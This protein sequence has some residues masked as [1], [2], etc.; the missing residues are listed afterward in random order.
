MQRPGTAGSAWSTPG[1]MLREHS[2]NPGIGMVSLSARGGQGDPEA[3]S[4]HSGSTAR[5]RSGDRIG[6]PN[7]VKSRVRRQRT[8]NAKYQRERRCSESQE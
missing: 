7:S 1:G 4:N 3:M 5:H 8:A 6:T 2:P